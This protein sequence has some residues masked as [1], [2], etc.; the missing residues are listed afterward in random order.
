M[1]LYNILI[2]PEMK[3]INVIN[4]F[5]DEKQWSMNVANIVAEYAIGPHV[6][7][8]DEKELST[9]LNEHFCIKYNNKDGCLIS[10]IIFSTLFQNLSEQNNIRLCINTKNHEI[11]KNIHTN[12]ITNDNKNE[13]IEMDQAQLH[14]TMEH[15]EYIT[16]I[17][18]DNEVCNIVAFALISA[19]AELNNIENFIDI[20]NDDK[21]RN[22]L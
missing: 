16:I 6:P 10:K 11:E 4:Q 13:L 20:D 1:K 21:T 19:Q 12:L 9:E 3:C 7:F 8:I 5:F 17:D 22:N 2:V 18:F 15:N 14:V